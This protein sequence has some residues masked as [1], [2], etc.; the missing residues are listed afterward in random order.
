MEKHG[1][2]AQSSPERSEPEGTHCAASAQWGGFTGLRFRALIHHLGGGERSHHC[3]L[4]SDAFSGV[5]GGGSP[6]CCLLQYREQHDGDG[7]WNR[8]CCLAS[9]EVCLARPVLPYRS[10]RDR[11]ADPDGQRV[12][13]SG[14]EMARRCGRSLGAAPPGRFVEAWASRRS[15]FRPAAAGRRRRWAG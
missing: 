10:G 7:G 12:G 13:S 8:H 6:A 14:A 11:H 5:V 3:W 15:G 9:A 4:P 2:W 1:F